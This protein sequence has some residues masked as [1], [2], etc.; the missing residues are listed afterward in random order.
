MCDNVLCSHLIVAAV[1]GT[2]SIGASSA[3]HADGVSC[4]VGYQAL[5]QKLKQADTQD[6]SA[7]NNHHW[8]V[9]VNRGGVVCAVAFSGEN[10]DAQ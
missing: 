1:L 5:K 7:F 10:R 2:G 8:A 3:A 9:V 4:P 6:S